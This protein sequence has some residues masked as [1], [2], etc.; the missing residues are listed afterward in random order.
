MVFA[1]RVSFIEVPRKFKYIPNPYITGGPIKPK[2]KGMFFGRD[3]VFKFIKDNISS[4]AQKN[5]LILQGERRSGKTSILYQV[6]NFLG[7]EYISVF[8]DGQEF[9]NLS[10]DQERC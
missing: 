5:V 9:G 1:D 10:S 2:S 3:D 4:A 7:S 8:M 6:K